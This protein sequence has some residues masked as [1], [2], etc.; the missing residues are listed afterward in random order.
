MA[1]TTADNE[2]PDSGQL[3][4]A[5]TQN[6]I[7][8]AEEQDHAP[9]HG[10]SAGEYVRTRFTSLKPPMMP[11]PNPF[12]LVRMLNRQ[13]WAFFFVAFIAWV[14]VLVLGLCTRGK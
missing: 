5:P 2:K 13:Q 9:H 12:R 14:R 1:D 3:N 6:S 10:M 7:A 4:Q 8:A 11:A